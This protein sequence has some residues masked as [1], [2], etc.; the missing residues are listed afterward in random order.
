VSFVGLEILQYFS[1]T[2]VIHSKENVGEKLTGFH[3]TRNK[4]KMPFEMGMNGF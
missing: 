1:K 3:W 4:A 2:K